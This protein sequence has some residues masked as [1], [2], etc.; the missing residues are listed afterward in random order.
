MSRI[1]VYVGIPTTGN[2]YDSN[3]H[4]MRALEKKYKDTVELVYPDK[5]VRRIFHDYARN[6]IVDEFMASD[7]DILWFLDSDIAPPEDILDLV[8]EHSG[9]W[10]L[11][12]APYPVFMTPPGEKN[13]QVLFTV[14]NNHGG[15]FAPSKIPYKGQDYVDGLATGCMFIKREV[16][17]KLEKPYFEFKYKEDSRVMTEGEDIGFCKKVAKLNY[18]FFIDY[19]MVCKHYKHVCLLEMNNYA[20]EYANKSVLAY[21]ASIRPQIQALA[22][23][24]QSKMDSTARKK[25]NIILPDDLR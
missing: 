10:K 11:A 13:P 7:C 14:Y 22:A 17:E 15:R 6:S 16:I 21:D 20:I 8:V 25:S 24:V 1:K 9:Q 3:T 2:L 18:K 12:G 23:Q 5:L 4:A 19:S